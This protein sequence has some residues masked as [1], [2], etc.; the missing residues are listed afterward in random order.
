MQYIL[1]FHILEREIRLS[2][3]LEYLGRR[4]RYCEKNRCAEIYYRV[5]RLADFL[6]S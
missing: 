1:D 5:L 4:T 2:F 3:D 6:V